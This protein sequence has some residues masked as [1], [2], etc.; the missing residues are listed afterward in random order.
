MDKQ[1]NI[2]DALLAK[3]LDGSTSDKENAEIELWIGLSVENKLV[4]EEFEKIWIQSQGLSINNELSFDKKEAFKNVLNRI[5]LDA[6]EVGQKLRNKTIKLT[7]YLVRIA[8]VFIIGVSFYFIYQYFNSNSDFNKGLISNTDAENEYINSDSSFIL[9]P[10]QSSINLNEGATVKYAKNF[11]ENRTVFLEGEAFFEVTKLEGK[12]FIVYANDIEVK[13]LG[14]SFYVS[15]SLKDSII[16]VS[17]TTGKVQVK[18]KSNNQLVQLKANEK[19]N[20]NIKTQSFQEIQSLDLNELFWKTGEL[21]FNEE[22]LDKVLHL[23][24]KVYKTQ[25]I[26]DQTEM[27]NCVF[28]GRFEN[29]SL[30]EILE[31][32]KLNFDII[33]HQDAAGNINITGNGCE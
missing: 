25:I 24:S 22:S 5:N 1:N 6:N 30:N 21:K 18:Q 15:S 17:V 20:F 13:V 7:S 9:L 10:D 33:I 26:F 12:P 27:R 23:L 8:A 31:Q 11:T 19:V 3:Y 14:T 28:T 32:L 16:E 4:F 29:S 2:D